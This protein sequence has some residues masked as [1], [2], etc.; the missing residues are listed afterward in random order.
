MPKTVI[1]SERSGRALRV[2]P[3]LAA[4]LSTRGWVTRPIVEPPPPPPDPLDTMPYFELSARVR[5]AGLT[6]ETRR[7]DDLIAALKYHRRDMVAEGWPE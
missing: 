6:P 5:E 7:R 3:R 1:I 2:S 4:H